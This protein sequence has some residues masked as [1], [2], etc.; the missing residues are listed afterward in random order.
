[1]RRAKI[2]VRPTLESIIVANTDALEKILTTLI[3]LDFSERRRVLRWAA[4]YY[5]IDPTKL[6]DPGYGP[7]HQS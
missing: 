6:G 2:R 7:A 3:A 5:G 4:E 1:M